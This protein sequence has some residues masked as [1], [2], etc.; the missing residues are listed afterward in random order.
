MSFVVFDC[1]H[2]HYTTG[3]ALLDIIGSTL[4]GLTVCT[5]LDT[6]KYKL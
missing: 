4:L 3:C 1:E 6:I 2:M 5:L